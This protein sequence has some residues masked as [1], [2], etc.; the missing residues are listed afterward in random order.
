MIILGVNPL[1]GEEMCA[2][3][4]TREGEKD[5]DSIFFKKDEEYPVADREKSM[6]K[7]QEGMRFALFS[8][9]FLML[10][11]FLPFYGT[12]SA[13]LD[14]YP[15]G[16]GIL[17]LFSGKQGIAVIAAGF[18]AFA[19]N[20][21]KKHGW[22][23]ISGGVILVLWLRH[24]FART[25]DTLFGFSDLQFNF[26][27]DDWWGVD[28]YRCARLIGYW[29]LPVAAGLVVWSSLAL[30]KKNRKQEKTEEKEA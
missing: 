14:N 24:F 29:V 7:P 10:S 2:V 8:A 5:M 12:S 26:R 27:S 1:L 11:V 17:I 25:L 21:Y 4:I 9:L 6:T 13:L 15:S 20:C 3:R 28:V 23:A 30:R 18:L 22:A 16:M 19:L